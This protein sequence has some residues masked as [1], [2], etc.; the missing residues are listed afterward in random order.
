MDTPGMR[1]FTPGSV[2][3]IK[4][5]GLILIAWTSLTSWDTH[6]MR[7]RRSQI[8]C[9][10]IRISLDADVLQLRR[11]GTTDPKCQIVNLR[12]RRFTENLAR[13]RK[14]YPRSRMQK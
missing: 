9:L 13:I 11:S 5:K 14:A 8:D 3:S 10:R 1:L 7:Y 2:S 6:S 4:P 12:N